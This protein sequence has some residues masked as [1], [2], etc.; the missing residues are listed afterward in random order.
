[1]KLSFIRH[2]KPFLYL[3]FILSLAAVLCSI[4]CS[5]KGFTGK[6]TPAPEWVFT[7]LEVWHK[8]K[9]HFS[10]QYTFHGRGQS[11]NQTLIAQRRALAEADAIKQAK[12]RFLD[13]YKLY[14]Q[15]HPEVQDDS[16]VIERLPWEQITFTKERFFDAEKNIQHA[17]VEITAERIFSVLSFE[18]SM[19]TNQSSHWDKTRDNVKLFFKA[20]ETSP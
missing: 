3:L 19:D 13:K 9:N 16:A 6:L 20:M 18:K 1:M 8:K 5:S 15:K 10:Q 7:D 17:L 14:I 11:Q 2:Q 4:G 12:K